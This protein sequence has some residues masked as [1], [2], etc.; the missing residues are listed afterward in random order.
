MRFESL[1]P[2]RLLSGVSAAD[3]FA[4]SSSAVNSAEVRALNQ[5]DLAFSENNG[6]FKPFGNNDVSFS[7][8]GY[9]IAERQPSDTDFHSMLVA[10]VPHSGC[11]GEQGIYTLPDNHYSISFDIRFPTTERSWLTDHNWAVITQMWGPRENGEVA[12]NPPFSI[13]TTSIDGQPTWR[14]SVRADAR[15]IS[16]DRDYDFVGIS[17]TPMTGIGQWQHW[18]IEYVADPFGGG[19]TRA[20][21]NGDLVANHVDVPTGYYSHV[22]GGPSGPLN[23][24]FG[25]YGNLVGNHMEAHFDNIQVGCSDNYQ[26][27]VAGVVTNANRGA[28]VTARN[29]SSGAEF[30]TT[31]TSAGVYTLNVPAGVYNIIAKDSANGDQSTV[32]VD[33]RQR[34]QI[35]DLT[36]SRNN[37]PSTPNTPTDPCIEP[38][39]TTKFSG[40]CATPTPTPTPTPPPAPTEPETPPEEPVDD[41]IEPDGTRKFSG[42]CGVSTPEPEPEP[43]PAPEPPAPPAPEPEPPAPEPSAPTTPVDDA[44]G[45]IEPDGTFNFGD[46]SPNP[47]QAPE[48]DPE[49]GGYTRSAGRRT[50]SPGC[51]P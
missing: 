39:G 13:H 27:S 42:D 41:C 43:P 4:F 26:R 28:E 36:I 31:T 5:G 17:D 15:R 34:S 25:I 12:L 10:R 20:W 19:L 3:T 48:P 21:L 38:D 1:E 30:K 2:R 47:P 46:C 23:P 32:R 33:A 6:W 24:A 16:S 7:N 44:G 37:T 49:P 11:Y 14:V 35:K 18:D 9:L 50:G 51:C 45:C 22:G 8:S 40:D 29:V